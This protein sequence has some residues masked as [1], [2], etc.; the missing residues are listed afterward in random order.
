MDYQEA[1]DYQEK[2]VALRRRGQIPDTLLLVEHPPVFTIGRGGGWENLRCS[3]ETLEQ[4]GIRVYEVNRG[5]NI[6]YHGPGQLVGYPI[7]DL[8][9]QG[10]DVRA[11]LWSLE[12]ILIRTLEPYLG[13]LGLAPERLPGYTGVWVANEKIAAIGVAVKGWITMHGFALNLNTNLKH[14]QLINPCGITDRGVTSL[15]R[16]LGR[17]VDLE[18]VAKQV[19]V[20]AGLTLGMPL[21]ANPK[22]AAVPVP[23]TEGNGSW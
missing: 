4:E 10:R 7:I 1:L 2:L 11:Y 16:L 5:G 14:F 15:G 18:A 9:A 6:T 22:F 23:V 19:A 12:E 17:E 13:P 3:R 8:A 21:R 20:Q